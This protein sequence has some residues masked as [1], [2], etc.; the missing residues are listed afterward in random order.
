[1]GSDALI[2]AFNAK[3]RRLDERFAQETV[4][5]KVSE[6]MRR[7]S[8]LGFIELLAGER[9]RLRSSL[10]RFAEPVRGAAFQAEALSRL[11]ASGEVALCEGGEVLDEE[12]TLETETGEGD[13][14]ELYSTHKPSESVAEPG[15]PIEPWDAV[16]EDW[17]ARFDVESPE[18]REGPD[19]G[20]GPHDL[21]AEPWENRS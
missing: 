15:P 3:K 5:T 18:S 6:A 4:R 10:M 20:D 13:E 1:M 9:M 8:A 19:A 16:G 2:A 14:P 11:V 7:L 17:G 12:D 21:G